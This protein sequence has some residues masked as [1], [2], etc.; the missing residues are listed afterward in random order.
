MPPGEPAFLVDDQKEVVC[1]ECHDE[2]Q[3]I[4]PYCRSQFAR[5]PK[6][7]TKCRA[8]G[9]YVHV[10]NTQRLFDS[11]ILTVDQA[12][13]YRAVRNILY[14]G[15]P[16]Q[17][18]LDRK[19]ALR[20]R[21][22]LEP[23][24]AEVI[25]AL[26]PEI[27]ERQAECEVARAIRRLA[28]FGVTIRDFEQERTLLGRRLGR[29]PSAVEVKYALWDQL[30]AQTGGSESM[31]GYLATDQYMD[32]R[33]SLAARRAQ[34]TLQLQKKQEAHVEFVRILAASNCCDAC[35]AQ[36]DVVLTIKEALARMPVP[37]EACTFGISQ[38][39]PYACCRCMYISV[40]R[41]RHP[42]SK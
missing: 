13:E 10:N 8:C 23:K 41:P 12:A 26:Q 42:A 7:R 37:C 28:E 14:L 34:T 22:G 29:D 38:T 6:A 11:T 4:C 27:S 30:I 18:Y 15:I 36:S 21:N 5:R 33:D 39:E 16:L 24:P 3:P 17:T 20:T 25:A 9:N 1:R 35:R 19:D 40:P 2:L 32:G 31:Y